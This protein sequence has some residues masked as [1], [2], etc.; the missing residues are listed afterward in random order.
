[1]NPT[2]TLKYVCNKTWNSKFSLPS[3]VTCNEVANAFFVR[4]TL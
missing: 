1:M 2:S 3:F 4:V